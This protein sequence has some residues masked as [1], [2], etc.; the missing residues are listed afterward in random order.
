MST[1]SETIAPPPTES[2][3]PLA[4]YFKVIASPS[5]AFATLGRV[6]MWGWAAIIG[7][8]LTLV[9]TFLT[10]PSSLHYAHIAQEQQYS[11]MPAERA[12]A[13]REMMAKVP[14]WTFWIFGVIGGLVAP[15]IFWLIGAVVFLAGAALG[16]G[17]P[18]FKLA[19]VSAVNLYAIPAL[20]A[21]VGGAILTLRGADS[22]NAATDL[23]ALPSLAMPIHTSPK[24]AAFLYGF[25]VVN[26]WYYIVAVIAIEQTLK[27]S[28]GAAI[29]TVVVLAL[30]FAGFAA[31]FA[32]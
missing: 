26:I 6:P 29:A 16:G 12:A 22:A 1:S 31:V 2:A 9:S 11:Q 19:W 5:E 3:S 30:L 7:V 18:R 28:R 13:A 8:I 10:L 21:I 25:N 27:V 4:T 32:K 24:L 14:G 17:E 20:G 15:W 23:Y